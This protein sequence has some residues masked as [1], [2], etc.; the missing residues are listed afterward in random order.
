MGRKLMWP[1]SP[2]NKGAKGEEA[3]PVLGLGV[4]IQVE[5]K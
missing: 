3:R 1:E 2:V 5:N 4:I